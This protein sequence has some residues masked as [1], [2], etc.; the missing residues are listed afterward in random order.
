MKKKVRGLALVLCLALSVFALVACGKKEAPKV[1]ADTK[2]ISTREL[3]DNINK[4]DWVVVDTREN[5]AF[6]GWKL[7]GV[8]RGGHIKG[9]TDFSAAWLKVDSKEKEATLDEALK[10]KGISTE[11][12]IVL[13]DANGKDA[14]EVADYLAQKGYKNLYTYDV[15]EWTKDTSL[16]MEAYPNYQ[17]IVPVSWVKDLVD[18]KNPETYNGKDFKIFEVSWGDETKSP[19]YLKDGHIKGAVHINTDEVEEGPLWNRLSDDKL[20][21]FAEGKGITIDTTVVLYGPDQTAAYRVAS[22]LKYLG[23]K[24]VRVLNGGTAKWKAAGY[25]LEKESNKANP[26][27]S[28]GITTPLNKEYIID[29]PEAEKILEDK[30]GSRLVDIRAWDEHIGKIS[31]YD[32][33]EPKGRPAG[34]VWGHG[35]KDSSSLQDYRNLD[36]TMRNKDEIIAMWKEWGI[37]P[38]QR[39]AFFCGTGWRA[40]E[41]AVY[42]E[43]IGVKNVSIYDGGWN[44]WSGN[45]GNPAGPVET[46]EP[47]RP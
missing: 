11:K 10:T 39:L 15:K 33:I 23:V 46:G 9:A 2:T 38:E 30:N 26:V 28:F 35:G 8:T 18:G 25:E 6:N 22:I 14:K 20:I 24:D 41:A 31:G 34:A 3:K 32:Y 13:Y 43:V 45:T 36:N 40:A 1:E 37:T 17:M 5:D 44:E 16:E 7:D 27:D 21:E 42:A 4:S 19:D 12:N 29:M 47:E